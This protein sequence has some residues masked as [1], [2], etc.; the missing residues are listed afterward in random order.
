M[1][2]FFQFEH[3]LLYRIH[4][5]D[6]CSGTIDPKD[7]QNSWRDRESTARNFIS[8]RNKVCHRY[9]GMHW[10]LACPGLA[11]STPAIWLVAV[12]PFT[13]VLLFQS[14]ILELYMLL[15]VRS[16]LILKERWFFDVP[17]V[18]IVGCIQSILGFEVY[19]RL[20]TEIKAKFCLTQ[21]Y[22]V[23]N[24]YHWQ[25]Y[26]RKLGLGAFLL[27]VSWLFFGSKFGKSVDAVS[28]W[29]DNKW[30]FHSLSTVTLTSYL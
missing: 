17:R 12:D 20:N 10:N 7:S 2:C 23:H 24:I 9:T 19:F 18:E 6:M 16:K 27:L 29:C 4:A 21:L 28:F 1:T 11:W 13:S 25:C 5:V 8:K 22:H 3:T 15:K 14:F 26:S 30:L